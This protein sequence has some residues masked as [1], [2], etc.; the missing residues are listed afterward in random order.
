LKKV[1]EEAQAVKTFTIIQ[2]IFFPRSGKR[3]HTSRDC[4]VQNWQAA[5]MKE[6]KDGILELWNSGI[7]GKK[8]WDIEVGDWSFTDQRSEGRRV[9]DAGS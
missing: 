5:N 9:Q 2:G 7:F 6:W 3:L 1:R 8:K 4:R